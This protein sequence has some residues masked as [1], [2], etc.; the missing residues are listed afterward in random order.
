MTNTWVALFVSLFLVGCGGSLTREEKEI[1]GSY[2][3]TLGDE[4]YRWVFLKNRSYEM[5]LPD[6]DLE[7]GTWNV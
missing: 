5:H 6:M 1:V 7:S 2:E 4:T 3:Q